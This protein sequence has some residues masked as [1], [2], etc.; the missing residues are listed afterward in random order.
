M[1]FEDVQRLKEIRRREDNDR[2]SSGS[3]TAQEVQDQNSWFA[4]PK[5]KKILNSREVARRV[6]DRLSISE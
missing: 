5:T 6:A 2:I 1:T 3:A 4:R